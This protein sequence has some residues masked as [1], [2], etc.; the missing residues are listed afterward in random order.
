VTDIGAVAGTI[1]A[2]NGETNME[3]SLAYTIAEACSLTRTGKTAL[4]EAIKTGQLR[5]LKRGRRTLVLP[6]DLREWIEKLPTIQR[7]RQSKEARR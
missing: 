1:P 6:T 3:T 5:A 4:Y 7:E 2:P